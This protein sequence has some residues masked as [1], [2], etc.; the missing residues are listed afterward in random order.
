MGK[1]SLAVAEVIMKDWGKFLEIT[2]G[3]LGAVFLS[4]I[5][6]SFLPYPKEKIEEA[7]NIAAEAFYDQGNMEYVRTIQ[8]TIPLLNFYVPDSLALEKAK[9]NFAN[10]NY[11]SS[12]LKYTGNKQQ[13][14]LQNVIDQVDNQ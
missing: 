3:N 8:S 14:Q 5:P 1:M 10:E 4:N 2:N 12:I 7:L 11:V 13:E 9:L 6:E